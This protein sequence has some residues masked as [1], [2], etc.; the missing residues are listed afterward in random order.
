MGWGS[1]R[2]EGVSGTQCC[3]VG[4][5]KEGRA[6]TIGSDVCGGLSFLSGEGKGGAS[7][8]SGWVH[9]SKLAVSP[10]HMG[11]PYSL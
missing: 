9:I 2:K 5:E 10:Y 6:G 3:R 4:K 11:M 1:S 7:A 8:W